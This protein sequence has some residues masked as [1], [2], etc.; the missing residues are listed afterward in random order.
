MF[1]S[2]LGEIFTL[3]VIVNLPLIC[4]ISLSTFNVLYPQIIPYYPVSF[5]IESHHIKCTIPMFHGSEKYMPD[6]NQMQLY[7]IMIRIWAPSKYALHYSA[8][9]IDEVSIVVFSLAD[10]RCLTFSVLYVCEQFY[11]GQTYQKKC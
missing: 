10:L 5:G 7:V 8:V 11:C 1:L 9:Y 3:G 6:V 4:S 2:V